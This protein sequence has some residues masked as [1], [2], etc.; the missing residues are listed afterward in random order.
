MAIVC[1]TCQ[2]QVRIL[3]YIHTYHSRFIPEGVAEASR[4]FF[5]IIILRF[6]QNCLA[7]RNT[8]EVAGGKLIAVRSQSILGVSAN[9]DL[10]SYLIFTKKY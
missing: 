1:F 6:Y 7:M 3:E 5:H 8:A 10:R 9:M 2:C 4:L